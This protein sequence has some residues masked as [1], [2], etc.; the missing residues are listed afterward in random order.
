VLLDHDGLLD[1]SKLSPIG[2]DLDECS[3]ETVRMFR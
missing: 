1:R 3:P 2:K